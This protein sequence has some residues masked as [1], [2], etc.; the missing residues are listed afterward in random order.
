MIKSLEGARGLAAVLVSLFH[1]G[2][3][4]YLPPIQYGYLFVDLFFVLSGF[5]ITATYSQRI[6]QLSD[7][8]PFLIRRFGRL[9]PLMVFATVLYVVAFDLGIWAKRMLIDFGYTGLLKN[10]GALAYMVPSFP[11]IGGTLFFAQGM[12]V[13]DRLILNKVSWSISVEF[14]TYVMFAVLWIALVGKSRVIASGLLALAGVGV[15]I[16]A[17]LSVHD[18]LNKGFCYDVTYDFGFARCIGAFFL[19]AFSFQLSKFVSF[20]ANKAQALTMIAMV[21]L[22]AFIKPYP[23]LAFAF[24]FVFAMLVVAICRDTGFV[25]TFLQRKPLQVLG[26]RSFSIYMLH[27]IVLLLIGPLAGKINRIASPLTG[28]V[29]TVLAIGAYVAVIVMIA[30]WSYAKIESPSRAWFGRLADR[31][32]KRAT[33]V[34][35]PAEGLQGR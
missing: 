20:S 17:T 34:G 35:S 6:T 13:F 28:A 25:A 12:G 14:Y 33:P 9:F 4:F 31:A 21:G 8:K 29:M 24:P 7:L 27:P 1:F 22:F 2:L 26:Q 18:C 10:P 5:V 30:G 16:W 3:A 32:G 15:T 19:G 23:T 11:E